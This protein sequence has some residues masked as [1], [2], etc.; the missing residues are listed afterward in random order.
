MNKLSIT[1]IKDLNSFSLIDPD[2]VPADIFNI[3]CDKIILDMDNIDSFNYIE[4]RDSLY[5]IL[6][7][8]LDTAECVWYIITYFINKNVLK[9]EDITKIIEK[10]YLFFKYYNNNYRPIYHLES[11]MFYIVNKVNKYDEL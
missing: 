6:T 9:P 7:Y 10:T 11:I 8:N 1:N 4:F 5:N 3:V 2:N